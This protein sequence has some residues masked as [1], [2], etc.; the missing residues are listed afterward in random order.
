[1]HDVKVMTEEIDLTIRKLLENAST[2]NKE[3]SAY[4]I[5]NQTQCHCTLTSRHT[6][7]HPKDAGVQHHFQFYQQKSHLCSFCTCDPLAR[8]VGGSKK[9]MFYSRLLA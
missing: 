9:K 1:V 4:Q 5:E 3:T 8:T 6:I 7:L 2:K